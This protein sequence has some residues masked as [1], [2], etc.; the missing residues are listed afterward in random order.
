METR[1]RTERSDEYRVRPTMRWRLFAVIAV[2]LVAAVALFLVLVR[3]SVTRFVRHDEIA[4]L[5]TGPLSEL[6]RR[7]ANYLVDRDRTS[8]EDYMAALAAQNKDV[9]Y[10][11][12]VDE[13]LEGE[14]LLASTPEPD[15]ALRTLA[16]NP[17]RVAPDGRVHR[18]GGEAVVDITE[19]TNTI[20]AYTV[21]LGLHK[22]A[23]DERTR[24]VFVRM[25]VIAL[26]I[27]GAAVAV[28]FG[29]INVIAGPVE[30]LAV[31]ATRL[32]LGDLRITFRP[33]G[34]GEVGNLADALD[35][36]KES[37]L[38]ALRR[39][40]P[41]RTAGQ[42]PTASGARRP[43]MPAAAPEPTAPPHGKK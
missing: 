33:R 3:D 42:S 34:R 36:L 9:V 27:A 18:I 4:R 5:R 7:C 10:V 30:K 24:D 23:I 21:H 29:A 17:R 25:G 13:S 43:S 26:V 37:V 12:F 39:C 32:S 2:V 11:C 16:E 31:D 14:R 20:P 8:I 1:Q 35:R 28:A 38:C 15:E 40:T 6:M 19:T 41:Q 22:E